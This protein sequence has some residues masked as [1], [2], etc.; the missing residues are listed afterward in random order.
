MFETDWEDRLFAWAD[1]VQQV[2]QEITEINQDHSSS[3]LNCS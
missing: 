2:H 3:A 1:A